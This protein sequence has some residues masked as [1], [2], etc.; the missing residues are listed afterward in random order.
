MK[1]QTAINV[2]I[3]SLVMLATCAEMQPYVPDFTSVEAEFAVDDLVKIEFAGTV[4]GEAGMLSLSWDLDGCMIELVIVGG[5]LTYSRL[6]PVGVPE[7]IC[8]VV[9][10]PHEQPETQPTD[11]LEGTADAPPTD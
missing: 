1:F 6:F 5:S 3:L 2:T 7:D 8:R 9:P 10:V 11:A 4:N